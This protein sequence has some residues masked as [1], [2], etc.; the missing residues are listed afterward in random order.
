MHI[1]I[2]NLAAVVIGA[3]VLLIIAFTQFQ[4]QQ[5]AVDGTQYYVAKAQMVDFVRQLQVDLNSLGAGAT[6]AQV[7]A[8]QALLGYVVSGDTTDV[9]TF[10]A[11]V[12]SSDF[13]AKTA[14]DVLCYRREATGTTVHVRDP[15]TGAYVA[16]PTFRIVRH[17]NPT[18]A[19]TCT[20]GSDLGA[21]MS[22][23][24]AFHVDLR[25]E[26]GTS[27]TVF[28]EVRQLAVHVRGVSP[29]GGGTTAHQG[30]MRQH[31]DETRWDG[32]IRP[33]NLTRYTP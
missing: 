29:V 26:N 16:T 10:R 17:L 23:L 4:G 15:A 12:D 25:R 3:T 9:L 8:G 20:G 11:Y 5:A 32:V 6:N 28:S 14:A 31:I 27:T 33:L 1:L 19:A 22:T 18:S 30:G 21:S 2:D 7:E 24:T 13:A